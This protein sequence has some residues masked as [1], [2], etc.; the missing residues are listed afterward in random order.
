[1]GIFNSGPILRQFLKQ[2]DI[3]SHP[4]FFLMQRQDDMLSDDKPDT[5]FIGMDT[6]TVRRLFMGVM[7]GFGQ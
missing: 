3:Q 5:R 6:P 4:Y 1:M 2:F 7:N